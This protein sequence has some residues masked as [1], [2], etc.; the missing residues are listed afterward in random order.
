[1]TRSFFG[2]R[3][4]FEHL[5]QSGAAAGAAIGAVAPAVATAADKLAEAALRAAADERAQAQAEEILKQASSS[6]DF[7]NADVQQSITQFAKVTGAQAHGWGLYFAADKKTAIN[8]RTLRNSGQ[9]LYKGRPIEELRAS[10]ERNK[11]YDRAALVEDFALK[12]DAD[13]LSADY[14]SA[15]DLDWFKK[16]ILPDIK[17]EGS[18]FEVDIPENDVLLDEQKTFNE[19][20]E[21]VRAALKRIAQEPGSRILREFIAENETGGNL[22]RAIVYDN[23]DFLRAHNEPVD[24]VALNTTAFRNASEI[25]LS[26]GVEGITYDG[27][28]DGRGYVVFN[29]KAIDVLNTFYQ[30]GRGTDADMFAPRPIDLTDKIGALEGKTNK[31]IANSI[32][33]EL[34]G[35][36]GEQLNTASAPLQIQ[37]TE[38]NKPH[39]KNA[40]VPLNRGQRKRHAAALQSLRDIVQVAQRTDRDGRVDLSH[41]KGK[42]LRHKQ[43]VEEYVYFSAPVQIN[44]E[45]GPVFYDV[46]L[47]TERIK[48]Q[49]PNLL[50]LYHVRVKRNLPNAGL[51]ALRGDNNSIGNNGTV[52]KPE[53]LLQRPNEP[54]ASVS[55][56]PDN[57]AALLR[58]FSSANRSSAVHEFAHVWRRDILR[59]ERLSTEEDFLTLVR[60]LRQWDAQSYEFVKSFTLRPNNGLTARQRESRMREID[61]RGCGY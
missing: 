6:A 52:V 43:N 22:Y 9:I 36:I 18:L 38:G 40:N 45:N 10:L 1:M 16:E 13:L 53:N 34:N 57:N 39:I 50:D 28:P 41:N 33:K 7:V 21:K 29:D 19:Q 20:P 24:G 59:A 44:T 58:L 17:Q 55:F 61:Q 56:D 3:L 49:D 31:E 27:A 12:M 30:R 60:D 48:G 32:E 4:R 11:Q 51:T 26:E 46:E 37:I 15:E 47:H 25:L 42:T 5:R 14:Y 23:A 35:L 54:L 8:Y 2:V